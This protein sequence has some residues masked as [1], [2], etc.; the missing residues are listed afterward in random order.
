M[1]VLFLGEGRDAAEMLLWSAES[2]N[3]SIMAVSGD[4]IVRKKA[5]DLHIPFY[6]IE[7]IYEML[8]NGRIEFD[9][10]FS[11]LFGKILKKP[12]IESTKYGCIN[13]HPAPLPDYKGRAGSSFAIID[14]LNEWG[15][16]AHYIDAGIDTGSIITVKRFPIEWK[17]ETGIS[18]KEKTVKVL[19]DLYKEVFVDVFR[20]KTISSFNQSHAGKYISKKIMLDAMEIKPGDDVDAKIQAFWFPP[21]EGA[22]ITIEN[23]KYMLIND[24]IL[25]QVS[26]VIE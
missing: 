6:E 24:F 10:T 17:K 3:M 26:S 16:S 7:K 20:Y 13:F 1:N 4:D 8:K 12:L 9:V 15:C 14:K 2:D 25:R 22:Y 21:H 18:L 11:F 19:K 23:K 5:D